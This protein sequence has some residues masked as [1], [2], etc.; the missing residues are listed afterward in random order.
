EVLVE[1][2][3]HFPIRVSLAQHFHG[4]IRHS[5][6]N[7][8]V[9]HFTIGKLIPRIKGH[10]GPS[11]QARL[12]SKG[13]AGT[14]GDAQSVLIQKVHEQVNELSRQDRSLEASCFLNQDAVQ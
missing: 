5:I 2:T 3:L 12:Q 8:I 9:R 6:S 1:L 13:A 4:Q 10:V 14:D 7:Q 11:Y